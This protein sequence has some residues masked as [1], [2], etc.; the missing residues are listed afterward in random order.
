MTCQYPTTLHVSCMLYC[1]H[2]F[3]IESYK[4]NCG[5]G[6]ALVRSREAGNPIW[7][8]LL[9]KVLSASHQPEQRETSI[10][11]VTNIRCQ[12]YFDL[13]FIAIAL[14][15][16]SVNSLVVFCS[17]CWICQSCYMDLSKLIHGFLQ[18]V[19]WICQNW[20]SYLIKLLHGFVKVVLCF[21]CPLP[22]KPS[23]VCDND[24][25]DDDDDSME[26]ERSDQGADALQPLPHYAPQPHDT[27]GANRAGK[28]LEFF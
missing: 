25:D 14:P 18:I 5:F 15:C 22:N 7:N 24:N 12:L 6:F 8:Q 19:T 21:S 20:Y 26:K 16:Q 13:I 27:G 10:L 4:A 1:L 17:N 9:I 11:L 23:L 2:H 3:K 28:Y